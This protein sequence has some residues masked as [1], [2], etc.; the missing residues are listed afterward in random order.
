MRMAMGQAPQTGP[1]P[2]T[3][4]VD[5]AEQVQISSLALLKMLKHGTRRDIT[6]RVCPMIFF[7]LYERFVG[8][9]TRET[10][11]M[12]TLFVARFLFYDRRRSRG[13]PDGSHGLNA[14]S[15]CG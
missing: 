9:S 1:P 11:F 13:S 3:P 14:R 8:L 10:F 12:L 2:D 7:F 6:L 15:V 4:Q 5:T